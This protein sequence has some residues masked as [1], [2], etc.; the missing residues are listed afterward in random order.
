MQH[1]RDLKQETSSFVST[2]VFMSSLN[3]VLSLVEHK[4]V[5]ITSGPVPI[6]VCD[7]FGMCYCIPTLSQ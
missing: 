4:K 3:F 2:L 1:L 6:L 5:F 7:G